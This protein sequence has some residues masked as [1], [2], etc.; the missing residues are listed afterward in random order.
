MFFFFFNSQNF[1]VN[2]V[3]YSCVISTPLK[4]HELHHH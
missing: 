4:Q 1:Q 2:M 3:G